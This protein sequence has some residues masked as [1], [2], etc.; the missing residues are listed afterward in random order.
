MKRTA[1]LLLAVVCLLLAAPFAIAQDPQ[2]GPPPFLTIYREEVK[3][4]HMGAY[5]KSAAAWPPVLRKAGYPG[6][7]LGMVSM[8]GNTEAWFL[9]G[10]ASLGAYGKREEGIDEALQSEIARLSAADGDHMASS[11]TLH[12]AYRSDLSYNPGV[13]LSKI[14]YF[15]VVTTR[16]RPGQG[17]AYTDMMKQVK[18]A[19]AKAGMSENYAVYQVT[20]GAPAGLYLMLIPVTSLTRADELAAEH[21]SKLQP[22][23][24]EEQ[25]AMMRKVGSEAVMFTETQ[26]FRVD[27]RLSYM[28]EEVIARDPSFW[29]P[30]AAA[31]SDKKE[32]K[33]AGGMN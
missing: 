19:H 23:F 28:G 2:T 30:K 26:H 18:E 13:D 11:R 22:V 9:Q 31:K 25:R 12:A 27:P 8:S 16:V 33:A 7:Y 6:H 5:S 4:G 24:T 14:R 21:G 29:A 15:T 10:A 3:P 1:A 20:A 17:E 32:K